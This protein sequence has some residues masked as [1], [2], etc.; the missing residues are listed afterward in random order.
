MQEIRIQ[1]IDNLLVGIEK[2]M[3]E[4]GVKQKQIE[5]HTY[6]ATIALLGLI[7]NE[8]MTVDQAIENLDKQVGQ[9][10]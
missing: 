10:K 5:K 8:E 6:Y 2:E 4:K 1:A 3:M 9:F 7:Q